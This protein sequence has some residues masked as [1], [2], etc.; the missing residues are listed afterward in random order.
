MRQNKRNFRSKLKRDLQQELTEASLPGAALS[1]VAAI[2]MIGLV[3]AE[4][5]SYLTISTESKVILDHF[6]SSTDDTLQVT[7]SEPLGQ[8]TPAC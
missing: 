2:V 7:C 4:L 1:V 6:E 5:N 8:Q 3:I